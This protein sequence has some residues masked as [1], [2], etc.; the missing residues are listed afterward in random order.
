MVKDHRTGIET[1]NVQS[2]MDG[3]I[4]L[5][6]EGKLRGITNKKGNAPDEI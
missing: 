6:I 3:E 4:N 1:S 2:V 5:F